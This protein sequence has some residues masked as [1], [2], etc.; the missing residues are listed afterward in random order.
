[1]A[2]AHGLTTGEVCDLHRA[3]IYKVYMLGFAPGFAYLGDLDARLHTPRLASPRPRVPA[4]SVGIGGEH[5]GVYPLETP[6]G[7]NIIGHTTMKLFDPDAPGA[8][9]DSKAPFYLKTGDRVKF[10]TAVRP[11]RQR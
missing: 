2:Q 3:P 4:G 10:V 1:V 5:T 8:R 6:G 7:W 9:H 11:E